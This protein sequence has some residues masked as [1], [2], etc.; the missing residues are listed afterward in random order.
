MISSPPTTAGFTPLMRPL[1]LGLFVVISLLG[2]GRDKAPTEATPEVTTPA[3]AAAPAAAAQPQTPQPD[4]RSQPRPAEPPLL[5]D[6]S[7]TGAISTRSPGSVTFTLS[8]GQVTEA[9][10]SLN[11]VSFSLSGQVSAHKISLGGKE[12]ED[13]LR[14]MGK[15]T[16]S[17]ITGTWMGSFA[18][19]RARGSWSA[20]R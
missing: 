12:G 6:G 14:L 11:G 18:G 4:P 15:G 20:K 5:T 13:F 7:Y 8:E 10:A 19:E 2:C 16:D 1:T 3:P 9:S 17:Q